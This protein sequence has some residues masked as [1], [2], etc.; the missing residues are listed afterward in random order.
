MIQLEQLP[1]A[2][3][4]YSP[5]ALAYIGDVVYEKLVR[6]QMILKANMPV[7]RL[8]Q[9]TVKWVCAAAQA[10]MMEVLLPLLTEEELAV[11]KRGRN[12]SSRPPKNA[13]IGQYNRA[14]GFE[15]LF[16]YLYLS[17]E[18]RRIEELFTLLWTQFSFDEEERT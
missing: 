14:T 10:E 15:A 11:Y 7:N 1:C 13:N 12:A 18:E 17:G 3:K 5:L 8:H 9:M 16:G 6:E 4:Q 2:P